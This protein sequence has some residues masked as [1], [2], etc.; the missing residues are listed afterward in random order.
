MQRKQMKVNK[1]SRVSI[2]LT[3]FL[4]PYSGQLLTYSGYPGSSFSCL[5]WKQLFNHHGS[6]Y[7]LRSSLWYIKVFWIILTQSEELVINLMVSFSSFE[8]LA[9]ALRPY[10]TSS[11]VFIQSILRW[12]VV[13]IKL[14][15]LSH[16]DRV[17][18]K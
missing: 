16:R 17:W 11:S 7:H 12:E 4:S 18:I 10:W 14:V 15:K 3:A 5:F 8:T 6:I 13:V 1:I 2:H 9:K